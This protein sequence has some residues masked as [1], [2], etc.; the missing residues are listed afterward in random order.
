MA[1]I[2]KIIGTDEKLVGIARL[3]WIY[4][5][6]GTLWL[7]ACMAF[8]WGVNA[9][10]LYLTHYLMNAR[11]DLG[12]SAMPF[13]LINTWITP[14]MMITGLILLSFYVVKIVTTEI[15]LTTSRLIH[16]HGFIFVKVQEIDI[17]EISGESLDL[18][19]FGRFWSYGYLNLDCRFIGDVHL[20]AIE[21]PERFVR[22]LHQ[23]RA[24]I[25]DTPSMAMTKNK[26]E[27]HSTQP[28]EGAVKGHGMNVP[29]LKP[30]VPTASAEMVEQI[31]RQVQ[32]E[33][34]HQEQM[35]QAA[36]AVDAR[37]VADIVQKAM[38]QMVEQ[39]ADSLRAKGLIHDQED[40]D[41]SPEEDL[42]NSFDEAAG[43]LAKKPPPDPK[44]EFAK[45]IH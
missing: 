44:D 19:M 3:H 39:V 34:T 18:G 1:Y 7:L 29:D 24:N 14:V 8:A 12:T 21:H 22:V 26:D 5:L 6:K 33:I 11:G 43:D 40:P 9:G 4:I 42:L 25:G 15:G 23:L 30:E 2:R 37:M 32:A 10:I 36:P 13:Y 16:K 35:P 41:Q 45:V 38:P 17:N 27:E 31:V 20:P 28:D